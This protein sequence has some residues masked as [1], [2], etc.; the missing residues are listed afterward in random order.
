MEP[1]D[2]VEP[3]AKVPAGDMTK[4]REDERRQGKASWK[5]QPLLLSNQEQLW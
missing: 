2:Q 1:G 3:A 4:T 5:L